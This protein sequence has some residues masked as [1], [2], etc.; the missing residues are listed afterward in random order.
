MEQQYTPG[1]AIR[2]GALQPLSL[3]FDP[4][5]LPV[6]RFDHAGHWDCPYRS[7]SRHDAANDEQDQ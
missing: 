4:A 3:T 6:C 5:I 2:K 7:S 1:A